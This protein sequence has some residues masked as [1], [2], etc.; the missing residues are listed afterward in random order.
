MPLSARS[1]AV[2]AALAAGPAQACPDPYPDPAAPPTTGQV[3]LGAG[4][5][6]NPYPFTISVIGS[7]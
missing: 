4:S 7:G 2:L 6:T 5:G 3:N 1:A